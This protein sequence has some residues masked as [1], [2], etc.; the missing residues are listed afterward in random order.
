[1]FTGAKQEQVEL[2]EWKDR[3]IAHVSGT[4]I[5]LLLK[6]YGFTREN[7]EFG[8]ALENFIPRHNIRHRYRIGVRGISYEMIFVGPNQPS[9]S[10][11]DEVLRLDIDEPRLIVLDSTYGKLI[12]RRRNWFYRVNQE[13][14]EELKDVYKLKVSLNPQFLAIFPKEY[15]ATKIRRT[16]VFIN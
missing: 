2:L 16:A 1:M 8:R 9:I 7:Y 13:V 15:Y 4:A 5:N 6:A 3:E 10:T 12:P 14:G 11:E